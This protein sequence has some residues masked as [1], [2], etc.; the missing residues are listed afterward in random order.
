MRKECAAEIRIYI[1]SSTFEHD[2]ER[3]RFVRELAVGGGEELEE[4]RSVL[5]ANRPPLERHLSYLRGE[6]QGTLVLEEF[7]AD[8]NIYSCSRHL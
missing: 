5:Q 6:Q 3:R 1:V 2:V 8:I 4:R 7:T